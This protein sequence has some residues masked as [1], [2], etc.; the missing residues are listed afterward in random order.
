MTFEDGRWCWA[1]ESHLRLD[2]ARFVV[3]MGLIATNVVVFLLRRVAM[4]ACSCCR[5]LWLGKRRMTLCIEIWWNMQT[6]MAYMTPSSVADSSKRNYEKMHGAMTNQLKI[7][8]G[9][10][11]ISV[12]GMTGII[13]HGAL[14]FAK[15]NSVSVFPPKVNIKDIE[16]ITEDK[17]T[18]VLRRAIGFH[19]TLQAYDGHWLGDYGGPM[20]LLPGLVITLSITGAL[21]AVLGVFEWPGNN[22]LPPE[23][24]LLPYFLPVHPGRMWC[25]CRMVYLPMSYLYGKRFVGRI[26]ST[27]LALR[28][29]LFTVPYHDIDGNE[30]RN[31]CAKHVAGPNDGS[32]PL[33]LIGFVH[34]SKLIVEFSL[35]N[36]VIGLEHDSTKKPYVKL[37]PN[38]DTLDV[39]DKIGITREWNFCGVA[40]H[41]LLLK[42]ERSRGRVHMEFEDLQDVLQSVVVCNDCRDHWKWTLNDD[43]EFTVKELTKMIEEKILRVESDSEVTLW[44]KWVPKK[45]NIFIWRALKG[46]LPV[47]EELDKRGIDLDSLLCLCCDT[48]VESCNHSLVLCDLAWRVLER[49]YKW[50]EMGNVNAFSIEELYSFNGNVNIPTQSSSIWQAVI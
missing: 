20:F 42:I 17:V 21:N 31:L 48:V 15:E 47:R 27:V 12:D 7:Q 24:W 32:K 8:V 37:I 11:V 49:I 9:K 46:R 28:K 50:G 14:K 34:P 44:N 35:P 29:E 19:S 33:H 5:I 36:V 41:I 10:F 18:N 2:P 1:C 23:M 39:T 3:V 16:D 40:Q 22:P 25:H 4:T 38:Y 30:A 45:V 43:G 13:L 6:P 26:T